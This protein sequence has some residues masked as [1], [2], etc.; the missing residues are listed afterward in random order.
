VTLT[1]KE[2]TDMRASLD[3]LMPDTCNILSR[4]DTADGQGGFTTTWGTAT[5]SVSC[6]LDKRSGALEEELMAASIQPFTSWMLTV[7]DETTIT[8]AHRVE[9]GS[10]TFNVTSV[11]DGKSWKGSVRCQL[12]K[13]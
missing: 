7:P 10:N 5:A 13:V 4:T 12:E 8:E 2:L 1:S 11:D 3:L 9:V 6:R